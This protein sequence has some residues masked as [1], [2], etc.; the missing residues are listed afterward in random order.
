MKYKISKVRRKYKDGLFCFLFGNEEYK[1]F[2]LAL[3]NAI[4]N[5]NYTNP[6]DIHI[7]TLN[8]VIYMSM[9]NDVSF[10]LAG[11]MNFYEHQSTYNPNMPARIFIYAGRVYNKFIHDN[12]INIY[13]SSVIKLPVPRCI[14]LK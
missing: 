1:N 5:S 12:K 3:Y 6:D 11:E 4:N 10:L 9:K 2:T 14:C 8:D 7:T 13:S